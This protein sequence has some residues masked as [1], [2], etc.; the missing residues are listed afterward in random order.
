M[1]FLIVFFGAARLS[2]IQSEDIRRVVE[3]SAK[4]AAAVLGGALLCVG[5]KAQNKL[6][7]GFY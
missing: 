6:W 3:I 1:A 4:T 5:I 2:F 7:K